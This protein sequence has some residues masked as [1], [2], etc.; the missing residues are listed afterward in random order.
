M[1]VQLREQEETDTANDCEVDNELDER[2]PAFAL[3]FRENFVCYHQVITDFYQNKRLFTSQSDHFTAAVYIFFS[4]FSLSLLFQH[5]TVGAA[6]NTHEPRAF[7]RAERERTAV[8][9]R[10]NEKQP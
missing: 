6:T 7:E 5:S 2:T 3:E 1:F 10:E 4:P 8:K 9:V